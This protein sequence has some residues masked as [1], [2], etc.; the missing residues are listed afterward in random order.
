MNHEWEMLGTFLG[1]EQHVLK[2]ISSNCQRQVAVCCKDMISEWLA[3][4]KATREN[5]LSAVGDMG[6][7]DVAATIKD[8]IP[9]A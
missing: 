2:E 4:G 9:T 1:I 8:N 6:R 7:N 3:T 5:L